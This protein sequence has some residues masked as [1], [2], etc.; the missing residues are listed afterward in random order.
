MMWPVL[1]YCFEKKKSQSWPVH[2]SWVKE[3]PQAE[4]VQDDS[5]HQSPAPSLPPPC[6]EPPLVTTRRQLLVP[7]AAKGQRFGL[8]LWERT[9]AYAGHAARCCRW[10]RKKTTVQ[11]CV[12]ACERVLITNSREVDLCFFCLMLSMKKTLRPSITP[13]IYKSRKCFCYRAATNP[14]FPRIFFFTHKAF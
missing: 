3:T 1:C 10:N 7:G 6:L 2:I 13:E 14:S 4:S 5:S 9:Y 11:V 12:C 8:N